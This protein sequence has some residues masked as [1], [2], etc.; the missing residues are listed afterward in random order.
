[1]CRGLLYVLSAVCCTVFLL[2]AAPPQ[3]AGGDQLVR[4]QS[5]EYT[6]RLPA[7]WKTEVTGNGLEAEAG[8]GRGSVRLRRIQKVSDSS[9]SLFVTGMTKTTNQAWKD[10]TSE[11]DKATVGGSQALIRVFHGANENGARAV[12]R[13]V[14][15]NPV[16]SDPGDHTYVFVFDVPERDYPGMLPVIQRMEQSFRVGSDNPAPPF[17]G[18][19][20]PPAATARPAPAPAPPAPSAGGDQLVRAQG[21]EYTLRLPAA[22]K[23]EVSKGGVDASGDGISMVLST[24]TEQA[25][26][27]Y[28]GVYTMQNWKDATSEDDT[29]IIGGN[30]RPALIRVFHG[31]GK[32]GVRSV[33]RVVVFDHVPFDPG[34][35]FYF[36]QFELR[37]RDYARSLPVIQRIE[38]SFRW[39]SNGP[40]PTAPS[41][42][43]QPAAAAR[44]APAPAAPA[45]SASG[46]QLVRAQGGE[47]TLRLP[48]AWKTTVSGSLLEANGDRIWVKLR[49]SEKERDL[50][51]FMNV[52]TKGVGDL[53]KN[54]TSED[55]Q[56]TIGGSQALI[57]V[58]HGAGDHGARVVRRIVVFNPVPPDPGD[59]TYLLMSDL[60]ERDYAGS[61][62]LIQRIEQSFR[63]G[64]NHP[65]PPTS[66]P[67][68]APA[69]ATAARHLDPYVAPNRL[70]A[71]YKPADWKVTEATGDGTFAI[72]IT[73]PDRAQVNLLWMRASRPNLLRFMAT[74]RG[75]LA[76]TYPGASYS[77]IHVSRDGTRGMATL[78]YPLGNLQAQGRAYFE[79]T[80]TG[81]TMQE[82]AAP[83]KQLAAQRP[84]LLNVMASVSFIQPPRD[85]NG[86]AGEAAPVQVALVERHAPDGSLS[87]SMP[88][89]WS[90]QAGRGHVIAGKPGGGLGFIFTSFSG[91][92]MRIM[93]NATIAQGVIASP[94]RRPSQ[95][96]PLILRGFGHRDIALLST[97]E[98][99]ATVGECAGSLRGGSC[100]AE[101]CWPSGPPRTAWNVS[102]ASKWSTPGPAPWDSGP[103][104]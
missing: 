23:T 37:E 74:C 90:F 66:S 21:G 39:V 42:A 81:A 4:A 80:A 7:A 72:T 1:M 59:H 27:A 44:P 20:A 9:L 87:L 28:S 99:R 94:Y 101:T 47:Y 54:P 48:A 83:E 56:A 67:A 96:L 57:R 33:R 92:P 15:F 49:F 70:Y 73:S 52:F 58:F 55:G 17:T 40:E 22:W 53:L 29:A 32:D 35:R 76:Q 93:A 60:A 25:G 104:S 88:E 68:P 30:P 41:P 8:G 63:V 2:A 71:L 31:A 75:G 98:D 51:Q 13:V 102:V 84:V 64:S 24:S 61:L 86:K 11:D 89:D 45:Q 19:P 5:G 16:P 78:T 91:N 85:P 50:N 36:F 46:D 6:L 79:A 62:P 18:P 26:I 3:S 82:Y 14:C 12:R 10:V 38:Q 103:A 65:A 43:P 77:D 95:T 34:K 97:A 69:G 100:E